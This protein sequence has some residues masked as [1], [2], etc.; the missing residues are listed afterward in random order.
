MSYERDEAMR[1]QEAT[2]AMIRLRH[3]PVHEQAWQRQSAHPD[4]LADACEVGALALFR[5]HYQ[6]EAD[7]RDLAGL[8]MAS[9]R[10][11]AA[12]VIMA[13]KGSL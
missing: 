9:Y 12:T 11:I 3:T 10:C 8:E 1:R 7:S 4:Q 5:Q 6:R 2:E 13:V